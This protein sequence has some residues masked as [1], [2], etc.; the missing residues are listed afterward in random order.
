MA[1]NPGTLL[2][3]EHG[4]EILFEGRPALVPSI[5]Q[6]LLCIVSLGLWLLPA[7]WRTRGISYRVTSRRIV[8]QT[9]VLS[10]RLEQVDLYRVSDYTVDRPFSQRLLGTGNLLLKTL[11]KNNP[12]V[13]LRGIKADVVAL[14]ERVRAA[15]EL[16]KGRRGVRLIDNE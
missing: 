2:S 5:G 8:V 1:A 15:T 4:E 9:G 7:W 3:A 6:L 11:D 13:A 14:Y 10:Q 12:E 16:E